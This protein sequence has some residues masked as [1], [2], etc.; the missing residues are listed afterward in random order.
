M[1]PLRRALFLPCL[2][3]AVWSDAATP[4]TPVILDADTGNEVDDLYAVVRAL[5]APDWQVLGL[6]ATH[7]QT[8]HWAVPHS[9][10]NSY[11]LNNVLLAYL[12]LKGEVASLRGAEGR[13]YDWG[14]K[15]RP[16]A[17]SNFIVEQGMRERPDKLTVIAL[18]ALTNVA[19]ALLQEPALAGR[20]RLYWL[21][22]NYD[23][24]AGTMRN[25]D[26]NSVMDVQALDIVLHSGIELH[27]MPGNVAAAMELEW[28]EAV[29][30]LEG[31]HPL[32]DFLLERWWDHLDGERHSR[33]IWDLALVQAMLHPALAETVE[34]QL[35]AEKGGRRAI[36]YRSIE[37][38]PMWEEFFQTLQAHVQ[39]LQP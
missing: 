19:S 13:L 26:F 36:L 5:I 20:L 35:S 11:R 28:T 17:A 33:V 38:E 30:R 3:L 8:S 15:S 27:I 2:L 31:R 24:E 9:M 12:G 22:S 4:P 29:A 18:G 1:N 14:E 7:W 34:V 6:N 25:V 32:L 21:G 23:F 39:D 10:E 37:A 16:S